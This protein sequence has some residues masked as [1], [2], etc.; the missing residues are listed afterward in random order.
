VKSKYLVLAKPGI[1]LGNIITTAGGFALASRGHFNWA[2]FLETLL[3]LSFIIA[4]ACVFNNYI[5]RVA[6]QKMQRT[7]HRPLATGSISDYSAILFGIALA[8]LGTLTLAYFTNALTVAVAL[9]GFFVYV[10]I[11]SLLKQKTVH[12][13]LIGSLA[14]AAPPIVGYTAVMNHLDGGALLLYAVLVLWQMPHFYAIAMY[15]LSD[16]A[17]AS[18][19]VLPLVSGNHIAKIHMLLYIVAFFIPVSL[20]TYYGYTGYAYLAVSALVGLIWLKI[21]FEGFK[22]EN[23]AVW[24]RQMFRFSLVVITL[25]SAM[26]AI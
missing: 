16:Y 22:A 4:S 7:K 20:L 6:D 5:D 23:D 8:V 3:G 1:I 18:T 10:V 25:F 9:F 14:G 11:Y 19:P 12:A 2:L 26:I 24:A 13:T 21:S 15:R 17:A